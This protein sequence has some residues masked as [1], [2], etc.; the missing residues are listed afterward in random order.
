MATK[1]DVTSENQGQSS[2]LM[3]NP[4]F[5]QTIAG[6]CSTAIS[7]AFKQR[8]DSERTKKG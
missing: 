5:W 4:E 8:E 2:D 7:E 3:K 1:E 6:V